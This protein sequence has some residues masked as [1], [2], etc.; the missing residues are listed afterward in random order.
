MSRY[1]NSCSVKYRLSKSIA[2]LELKH[3]IES[4][5]IYTISKAVQI[6]KSIAFEDYL[7]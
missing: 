4:F 6:I 3:D 2:T 5:K 7:S 1:E